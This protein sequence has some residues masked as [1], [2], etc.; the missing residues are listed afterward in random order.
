MIIGVYA[1]YWMPNCPIYDY[2]LFMFF[3]FFWCFKSFSCVND[4]KWKFKSFI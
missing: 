4:E 2:S 1:Y 3:Y